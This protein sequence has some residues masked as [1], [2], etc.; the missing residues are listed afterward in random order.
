MLGHCGFEINVQQVGS[1]RRLRPLPGGVPGRTVDLSHV[2]D[3]AA[4]KHQAFLVRFIRVEV[5]IE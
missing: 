5:A 3:A 2:P 1:F 4:A